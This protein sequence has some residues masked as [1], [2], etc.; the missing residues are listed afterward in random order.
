MSGVERFDPDLLVGALGERWL[1]PDITYKP[2]RSCRWMHQPLTALLRALHGESVDPREIQEVALGTNVFCCTPRFTTP[3]PTTFCSRQFSIPQS[4]AMIL[5]GIPVGAG[6]MDEAQ[7]D[8]PRRTRTPGEGACRKMG[9]A[10][11]WGRH[12]VHE[13][14]R[15]MPARADVVMRDGRRF[16]AET[17]FALGDPWSSDTAWSH[18]EVT[19]KFKEVSGLADAAADAVIDAVLNLEEEPDTARIVSAMRHA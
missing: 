10:N 8:D 11:A 6:W 3:E 2:W 1:L 13:Q 12:I 7:D 15:N 19:A 18:A 16:A 14:W 9:S 4:V 5:L 17:E